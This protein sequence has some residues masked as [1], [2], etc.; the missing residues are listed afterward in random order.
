MK[1][2]LSLLLALTLALALL[3]A[4][5]RAASPPDAVSELLN[6]EP[7]TPQKSGHVEIDRRIEEILAASPGQSTAERFRTCYDWLVQNVSYGMP[8]T[9]TYAYTKNETAH[10]SAQMNRVFQAYGPLFEGKGLCDHYA[11]ALA[12]MA[13]AIGLEA[14]YF[15]SGGHACTAVRLGNSWYLFDAQYDDAGSAT[16]YR[17]YG[18]LDAS[19]DPAV[20]QNAYTPLSQD[21]SASANS[22]DPSSYSFS[23]VYMLPREGIEGEEEKVAAMTS[24][25]VYS[26]VARDDWFCDAAYLSYKGGFMYPWGGGTITLHF[27]PDQPATRAV[28]VYALGM[29]TAGG[30]QYSNMSPFSDVLPTAYYCS[31]INWASQNQIISGYGDGRFGPD[32]TLTREQLATVLYNLAIVADYRFLTDSGLVLEDFSDSSAVSSY[33]LEGMDWA[34]RIGL[35]QGNGSGELCPGASLTR[36][37]L[38]QSIC[39]FLLLY[40]YSL[41]TA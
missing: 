23:Y 9:G 10:F 6:A 22:T 8:P 15:G 7:L 2:T 41:Q 39:N 18:I 5:A 32:D 34:V 29:L 38:A 17:Y 1:K 30:M 3:P 4:P 11:S 20:V 14:G 24:G 36:A 19:F 25:E 33:A 37:E 35:F 21:P 31:S 12:L 26:D 13:R 27:G 40:E 28:L 16:P